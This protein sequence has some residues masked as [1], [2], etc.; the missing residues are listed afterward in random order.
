MKK[1]SIFLICL[2]AKV[3]MYAQVNSIRLHCE[4]IK[5]CLDEMKNAT[6]HVI[7][8]DFCDDS[9]PY[10][11]MLQENW[12][13]SNLKF[14]YEPKYDDILAKPDLMVRGDWFMILDNYIMHKMQPVP[15]TYLSVINVTDNMLDKFVRVITIPLHCTFH[16]KFIQEK[17]FRQDMDVA[18]SFANIGNE[19]YLKNII[20]MIEQ[21]AEQNVDGYTN[22]IVSEKN[23]HCDLIDSVLATTLYIPDYVLLKPSRTRGEF[24]PID[25]VEYFKGFESKYKLVSNEEMRRLF[26]DNK[27]FYYL[28]K[29]VSDGALYNV[30]LEGTTGKIVTGRIGVGHQMD[31]CSI[32]WVYKRCLMREHCQ[33]KK[34]KEG[35][36]KKGSG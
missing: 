22:Y 24:S 30:I 35:S 28:L 4:V 3:A 31:G 20:E 15:V 27:P 32:G 10:K 21:C 1:K 13:F 2:F 34:K 26:L 11:K 16:N 6:V 29:C 9:K 8:K 23:N 17:L 19:Y 33:K 7:I 5:A 14:D 18:N 25:T 36:S 12:K